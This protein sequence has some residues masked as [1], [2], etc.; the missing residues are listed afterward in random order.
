MELLK[1]I[2]ALFFACL[3]L[4]FPAKIF[5]SVDDNPEYARMEADS[6]YIPAGKFPFGTD[7]QDL[8]GEGLAL[9]IPKPWYADENPQQEFFL[10][11]FYIDRYEVTNRRYKNYIDNVEAIPPQNWEDNAWPEGRADYP[12]VWVNWYDAVNFCQWA[13]KRLPTEKEWEKAARGPKGNEYPWGNEFKPE[14]ANLPR[15]QGSKTSLA[16]A[17]SFPAG[18]TPTGIHDLV[19]NVWEWVN[20]DYQPYKGSSY[21]NPAFEGEYKVT[22][23]LSASDIGHFPGATYFTVLKQFARAGYRQFLYPD[24]GAPDLGFR[25]A[26]AKKPKVQAAAFGGDKPGV[27]SS[28]NPSSGKEN[29]SSIVGLPEPAD[30]IEPFNP[31]EAKTNL[32]GSG[33]ILLSLLSLIAGLFSFLSP[34]TLPILPAYFAITAQTERATMSLMSVAFFCGLATLFVLMGA[35]ASFLGSVL[36][37]YMIPL[38]ELGGVLVLIFGVMTILGKGFSGATFK[39]KPAYTFFGFF[40]FGAT[41]ALGWTPCVGPVLSGILIL[42]ASEKTIFQGMN[43]LFFYAVGLGLPLILLAAF[44]S[45]LGRDTL[46]WRILRGKA[47]DVNIAG[48]TLVLHTTNLFSGVLLVF[49]GIALYAGYLTYL[50]SLLPIEIQIWFSGF[51]EKVMRWFD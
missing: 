42:A 41:F 49:L 7:K 13:G 29:S 12:V 44:C 10:K 8:K 39:S 15:K 37:D 34:C 5:A 47:W 16:K 24:D 11:G 27:V 25:C 22:R 3:L 51:E 30:P 20:D 50:N 23:G 19:G 45:H 35:S 38:T 31:F 2:L 40:L 26:S 14:N 36:R 28:T 43:L 33:I 17:G 18:A 32:P 4:G 9:G 21:K 1:K 48:Q 6:V 46:F